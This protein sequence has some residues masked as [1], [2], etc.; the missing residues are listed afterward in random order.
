VRTDQEASVPVEKK[1]HNLSAAELSAAVEA[2]VN[3]QLP[4]MY[5]RL[6]GVEVH[7]GPD[8]LCMMGGLPDPMYNAVYRVA[9]PTGQAGAR[10][11]GLLERYRARRCL[12]M[13]W[14]ITP[15]TP[16]RDLATHLQARGFAHAFRG[17][18]MAANLHSLAG[19]PTPPGLV[20]ERVRTEAQLQRWLQ[21]VTV[22]F[23]L[24]PTTAAAFSDLFAAFGPAVP[25]QLF[26]GLVDGQ[27]VAASRL[28]CAAGVAGIYH[29]ATLP[30]VRRQGLG[31]AM[32]LAAVRAAQQLGYCTGILTAS[33]AGYSL[34]RR[35][36]FEECVHADI[37][38][39][40]QGDGFSGVAQHAG[41]QPK[42]MEQ[43]A[44]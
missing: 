12:P 15:A 36:G 24:H 38:V 1:L 39:G 43:E 26:L 27:P 23:D 5:A 6:P 9:F 8:L 18:G 40:P 41:S 32:T 3:A 35:L 14:V 44:Q 17:V 37:Y 4:L 2:N 31:A 10:I 20:V 16:P 7:D 11:D 13:T 34:Y 33:P 25:W 22:A 19:P 29:V 30:E 21:P 42:F 28:F